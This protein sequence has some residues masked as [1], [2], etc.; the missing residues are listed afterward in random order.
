MKEMRGVGD[1]VMKRLMKYNFKQK[2][3]N[4]RVNI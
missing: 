1:L 3:Y 4:S 2:G